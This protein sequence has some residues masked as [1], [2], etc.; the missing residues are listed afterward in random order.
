MTLS[1]VA[2]IIWLVSLLITTTPLIAGAS[3]SS[4]DEQKWQQQ[5]VFFLDAE[6]AL[7]SNDLTTYQQLRKK[8]LDY[9]LLVYLDYQE[10]LA[11]LEQQSI[12][13]MKNRLQ[14]L[15][16]TPLKKQLRSRWLAF[17]AKQELWDVYL[18]FSNKTGS[19]TQQCNRLHAYIATGQAEKAY[20]QTP[21]LWLSGKS[22]P[23]ACDPVF[24]HWIAAGHLTEELVWKRFNLAISQR[25]TRLARYLKQYLNKQESKI[26]DLWLS[27]YS[28]PENVEKMLD[29]EHPM[30]DEMV[31]QAIRRL[32]W[33][34]VRAAFKAWTKY[35]TIGIF[36]QQQQH[37]IAYALAGG[38]AQEPD[39]QLTQQLKKLLPDQLKLDSR[40]SEKELQAALN[41]KDW[42]W[43]LR[44]IETF[45][46][47][48]KKQEQSRYWQ[49]RALSQLGRQD[50]A[51]E[52]LSSLA[53]Q[54]SYYGFLSA[55]LLGIK[56]KLD[57]VAL[58]AEQGL[59][60]KIALKPGL[61]RA[62]ELH[63]LNR[64]RAARREWNLAFLNAEPN[65]LKAAARLAQAWEWPSQGIL[66]LAKLHQ[67]NDLELRFPLTHRKTIMGQAKDHGIDSAW[68]YA[69]L[70]QES[71]FISD[72]KSP[73]GARGLM[74]LMPKTA[75]QVAKELKQLP[76]NLNDLFQP[77][78]NIKLGAGYLNKIYH[79]LQEN[80]V[81]A[82]AAYNAG[83]HRVKSWLPDQPQATDIWIETIP[84]HETREYLK[85]VFAYTVI[86]NYRLGDSHKIL[87]KK[88]LKPIESR[89]LFPDV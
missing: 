38:L 7:T 5:R 47:K 66:T 83:P 42:A 88:W 18:K 70:R 20:Q 30:R 71:A 23:N 31:V 63:I 89:S 10:T 33:R 76:P 27:L 80:P 21:A 37:D 11:T 82:T 9:P 75:T 13:S 19:T 24:D 58:Q 86:Y 65:E 72:A 73:A 25:Q 35:R 64:P 41:E 32:A 57:H 34:D 43:V 50:E 44:T 81:L 74:Q 1:P 3:S 17:L 54:R 12:Q 85:R 40:L 8:L 6:T 78:V 22:Q 61:Q 77:E 69:I 87:P 84:F 55:K 59:T 29:I 48:Q 14:R 16:E 39:R 36:S 15:E 79:Q 4:P 49:A 62:R 45:P 67:W 56:A 2:A 51:L 28:H 60:E 52:I 53:Q 68:I 26:A 46:A